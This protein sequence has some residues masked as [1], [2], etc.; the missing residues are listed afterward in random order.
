LEN[1]ALHGD[2][3]QW[4]HRSNEASDP[5]EVFF[6]WYGAIRHRLFGPRP[7]PSLEI[8]PGSGHFTA[9]SRVEVAIDLSHE[10]LYGLQEKTGCICVVADAAQLPFREGSFAVVYSNDVVHHLKA[11][12]ILEPAA[13]EVRRVLRSGGAWCI[14]DRL[15]SL[16][17]SLTLAISA[18]GRKLLIP[19]L[20]LLGRTSQLAGSDFEPPLTRADYALL[21]RDME[22]VSIRPWRN[23][24]V[25]WVYGCYQFL[26]LTLPQRTTYRVATYAVSLLSALERVMPKSLRCDAC[27]I[28]KKGQSYGD[29]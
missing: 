9:D 22:V 7:G 16:Y 20:S 24:L 27:L 11:Q 14:S 2:R 28:L 10:A 8:G 1:H 17:N 6:A 21:A 26:R 25:F 23:W 18:N 12:G 19:L 3:R 15:P 13:Q 29:F 4:Q 5:N